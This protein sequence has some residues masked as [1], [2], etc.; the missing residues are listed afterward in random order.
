[1]PKKKNLKTYR[2]REIWEKKKIKCE[3][4]GT[5]EKSEGKA[6]QPS[7]KLKKKQQWN[8][9]EIGFNILSESSISPS[10]FSFFLL[11]LR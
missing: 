1:M 5:Q 10:S 2:A 6:K 4:K 11:K 9:K 3:I 8:L 7:T